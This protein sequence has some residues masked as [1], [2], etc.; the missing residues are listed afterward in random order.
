M[1]NWSRRYPA[2]YYGLSILSGIGLAHGVWPP[3]FFAFFGENRLKKVGFFVISLLS[4]CETIFFMRPII[5]NQWVDGV[6]HLVLRNIQQ[7]SETFF[8]YKGIL[9]C[10][11]TQSGE[12][13]YDLPCYFF[14]KK[15]LSARHHYL[16]TGK[17]IQKNASYYSLLQIYKESSHGC[18]YNFIDIRYAIKE[19]LKH[20]LLKHIQDD[21]CL[22]FFCS[23]GTG[24]LEGDLLKMQFRKTGLSHLLAIS[25]FHYACVF[26]TIGIILHHI[27][28]KNIAY[29]FLIFIISLYF[30]FIGE[31]PSLHRAW[32]AAFIYLFGYLIKRKPSA[33]NSLGSALTISLLLDPLIVYSIGFQLSYTATFSL[34]SIYPFV[35][36]KLCLYFPMRSKKNINEFPIIQKIGHILS[37]SIRRLLALN[38]S[39]S[40]ATLPL[41]LFHFHYFPYIG[42]FL[43]L[44]FPLAVTLSMILLIISCLLFFSIGPWILQC[45]ECYTTCFLSVLFYGIEDIDTGIW[46]A[47]LPFDILLSSLLIIISLGLYLDTIQYSLTTERTLV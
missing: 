16:I 3:L 10:F 19:Q 40:L 22:A 14:L 45:A 5:Q 29:I 37:T 15:K 6:G 27:L 28:P 20:F 38:F 46:C 43:N 4:C 12:I 30:L 36:R 17:I 7:K 44:F 42:L 9:S 24:E 18:A 25:G 32:L 33:L 39:I 35:E 34:L 11:H 8:Y 2:L 23:L 21:L 31:T 26:C 13:Y 47:T 41:I 1:T